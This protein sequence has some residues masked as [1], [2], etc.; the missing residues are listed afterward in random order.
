MSWASHFCAL[1]ERNF[2]HG[3]RLVTII[4]VAN[5]ASLCSIK[6]GHETARLGR[7]RLPKT[8]HTGTNILSNYRKFG[9][10]AIF[11]E[12]LLQG[13]IISKD[14]VNSKVVMVL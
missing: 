10:P 5:Y 8:G 14:T 2:Q 13:N 1:L 6:I 7:F 3:I 12:Y 4:S 11:E 9:Y